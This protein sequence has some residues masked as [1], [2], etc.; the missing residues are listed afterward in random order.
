MTET[1]T[2]SGLVFTT[3][4]LNERDHVLTIT[5]NRPHKKNAFNR[6]MLNELLYVLAYA[7]QTPSVR[8]VVLTAVGN[9]FCAGADLKHWLGDGNETESTVPE[10]GEKDDASDELALA[11]YTLDKPVI[12]RLNG[13]VYAGGLLMV[14]NCT[15]AIAADDIVF[16]AP[17]I[18]RG[19]WPFKVMAG[20]FKVMSKRQGLDFIMRG[21]PL[22]AT[23]A[24]SQGLVNEQV[25]AEK[26]DDRVNNLAQQL[27]AQA[28]NTMR[29]GL[30]AYRESQTMA[31]DQ[32]LDYLTGQLDTCLRS[33]EAQEGIAAF[34]EKRSPQWPG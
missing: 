9:V 12:A 15:H 20:L 7:R 13:S 5:L 21:E 26:L 8:V 17:E 3:L 6:I 2:L 14:C 18:K 34:R 16:C 32:A 30:K 22:D 24:V 33:P 27:A 31:F 10:I 11:I 29:M 19:I 1:P 23:T 25:A 4:L 28:P